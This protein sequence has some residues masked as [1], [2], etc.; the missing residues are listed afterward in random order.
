MYIDFITAILW[1]QLFLH[2]AIAEHRHP[3]DVE[4]KFQADPLPFHPAVAEH[5]HPA[6]A[7]HKH[8]PSAGQCK[9]VVESANKKNR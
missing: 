1:V 2:P 7:E 5:K 3:A 4:H 8:H 6:S 9:V